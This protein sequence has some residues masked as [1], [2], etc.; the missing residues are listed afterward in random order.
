MNVT[1]IRCKYLKYNVVFQEKKCEATPP[2]LFFLTCHNIGFQ[3]SKTADFYKG[4][5]VANRRSYI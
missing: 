3:P 2:A 4:T 5:I 1:K